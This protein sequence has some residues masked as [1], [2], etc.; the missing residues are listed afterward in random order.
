MSDAVN[1]FREEAKWGKAKGFVTISVD[2]HA[3]LK[4]DGAVLPII[5]EF[6]MTEHKKDGPLE[7]KMVRVDISSFILESPTVSSPKK[8]KVK[9]EPVTELFDDDVGKSTG[10]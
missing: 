3:A 10:S 8:K 4:K 2:R 5:D 6:V 7:T 1:A 9:E